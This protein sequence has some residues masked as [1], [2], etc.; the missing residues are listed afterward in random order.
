MKKR[1]IKRY[2]NRKLYDT[3]TKAYISLNDVADFIRQEF[4]I[5]VLDTE[6]GKD[7]TNQVLTQV[8]FEEGK[9]GNSTI[10][11][12][13]LHE[14]IRWGGRVIDQGVEQVV[15]GVDRLVQDSLSKWI[16]PTKRE[17]IEQLQAKVTY[18]EQL[19]EQLTEH[20]ENQQTNPS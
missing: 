9:K 3:E 15:N 5:E 12:D 16:S 18:L 14:M 6:T 10:P 2:P 11:S 8:I 19:I 4:A 20:I 1:L 7:L 13:V 17:E